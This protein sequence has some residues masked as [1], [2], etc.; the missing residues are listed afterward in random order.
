ME[1]QGVM[2]AKKANQYE[3][4]AIMFVDI[5]G[6]TRLY[7]KLGDIE[8]EQ[9]ID[10]C[11][12]AISSVIKKHKGKIIKTIG[13]EVMSHFA[14]E[15]QAVETACAIQET[16]EQPNAKQFMPSVRIGLHYGMAI[17]KEGDLFGD[18]VNV[19]ARVTAIAKGKQIITTED[20]IVNLSPEHI[21]IIRKFDKAPLKGKEGEVVIYEVLWQPENA[22]QMHTSLTRNIEGGAALLSLGY[23]G[24]DFVIKPN[25]PD[26]MIGR[27]ARCDLIA[28]SNF[29]S[30]IHARIEYRRGKF[31]LIDQSTNGTYVDMK[32]HKNIYIRREEL[33]LMGV[34]VIGLGEKVAGDG[35]QFIRYACL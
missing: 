22:T 33:P 35:H 9:T 12:S 17:E 31:V 10:R 19:A 32:D 27:D 30:R 21:K 2:N 3:K 20:T 25:A 6:S 4:T 14:N 5:E 15:D 8:A 1:L 13:D 16:L 18:A 28:D 24:K 34:G 7:E 26:F 11:L 29:S 23:Q